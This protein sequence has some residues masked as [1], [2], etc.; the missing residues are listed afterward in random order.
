MRKKYLPLVAVALVI[1]AAAAMADTL[2]IRDTPYH[3]FFYPFSDCAGSN[4]AP[5]MR[6]MDMNSD[7]LISEAEFDA[8]DMSHVS[9]FNSIDMNSDG[10]ISP[11]EIAAYRHVGKCY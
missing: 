9:L 10:F 7:G 4:A 8:G 3:T 5:D 11:P 2:I 6:V 1:S